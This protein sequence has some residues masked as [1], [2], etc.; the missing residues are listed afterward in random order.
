MSS[1]VKLSH[2]RLGDLILLEL[3]SKD[4]NDLYNNHPNTLGSTFVNERYINRDVKLNKI[5]HFKNIV[6]K[7]ME[8]EIFSFP[9]DLEKSTI[10]HLRLGDVVVEILTMKNKKDH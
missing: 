10:I 3:N 9:H 5:N 7:Y 6:L 8:N 2:Y 4:I 1:P